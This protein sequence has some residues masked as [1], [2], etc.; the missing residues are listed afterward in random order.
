MRTSSDVVVSTRLLIYLSCR[1]SLE[2]HDKRHREIAVFVQRIRRLDDAITI[3]SP[4]STKKRKTRKSE[5]TELS[6][7]ATGCIE[8]EQADGDE[9]WADSSTIFEDEIDIKRLCSSSA[10]ENRSTKKAQ[11]A[12]K[13][14]AKNQLRVQIITSE[15]IVH[16]SQALHPFKT[17][18]VGET[19]TGYDEVGNGQGLLNNSTIDANIA[20]NTGTFQY[21]SLRQ[22]IN[23]KKLAKAQG[24]GTPKTPDENGSWHED[25]Q[26]VETLGRLEIAVVTSVSSSR[27]K[28]CL[29]SKLCDAIH[30]D[31]LIVENEDRD[32]MMRMA[33]Y[34]RYVN[35]RTYNAMIRNNQLWDWATGAKLDEIEEADEADEAQVKQEGLSGGLDTQEVGN[36]DQDPVECYDADFSFAETDGQVLVLRKSVDDEKE[37]VEGEF[38]GKADTRHLTS[39]HCRTSSPPEPISPCLRHQAEAVKD[40]FPQGADDDM[41]ATEEKE[42][43]YYNQHY[44]YDFGADLDY[45]RKQS[46]KHQNSAAKSL[47][48]PRTPI[49]KVKP[50]GSHLPDVAASDPQRQ[51]PLH[52]RSPR[53]K[54][55]ALNLHA[56]GW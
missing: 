48:P 52:L 18:L 12:V 22:N 42:R 2:L 55:P 21:A 10:K 46:T 44:D 15:D 35:K 9:E 49:S 33:G 36:D 3:S 6:S 14:I 39:V 26:I 1:K 20:F 54:A 11:K 47:R 29:L 45:Y 27:E 5:V 7:T 31:L 40:V 56:P 4:L 41:L 25:P 43:E 34:W 53:P 38:E 30:N 19:H 50:T 13:K 8:E 17:Y 32:T 28:K 16:I 51:E 23:A 37:P 24:I